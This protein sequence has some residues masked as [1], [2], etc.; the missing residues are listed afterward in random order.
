MK[1]QNQS[2]KKICEEESTIKLSNDLMPELCMKCDKGFACKS[3]LKAHMVKVHQKEAKYK[4]RR[5]NVNTT[6]KE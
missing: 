6:T 5:Y 1:I 2:E 4:R 3:D